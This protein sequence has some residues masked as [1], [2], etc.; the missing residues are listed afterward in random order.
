MYRC[1][2][3]DI[4][5]LVPEDMYLK[6]GDKCWLLF[7]ERALMTID[8]IREFVGVPAIINNWHNKGSYS[9]RGFRTDIKT[10]APLSQH[11]FGRAF[12]ITFQTIKGVE[13]Y[14]A[15]RQE[16]VKNK[17]KFPYLRGLEDNINWLHID[18]RNVESM[19]VFNP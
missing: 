11:R 7:D 3:F 8:A 10:G 4:K 9:Q 12:D 5:E 19:I 2:H 13:G 6:Y 16:I 18:T 1:K 14:N 17:A 15:L